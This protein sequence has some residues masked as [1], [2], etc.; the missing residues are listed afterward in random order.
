MKYSTK[1]NYELV[2]S[3]LRYDPET[4]E[5]SKVNGGDVRTRLDPKGY[6]R[7]SVTGVASAAIAHRIAWLLHTG[8]L[9]NTHIDHIDGDK[10]NNKFSNL[11][12]CT[13]IQNQH[14]QPKRRNNKSGYKGVCWMKSSKRWHA[15]ICCNSKIRHL[16]LF[17]DKVE[18]AKA[19]DRAALE[20]HGD[21]SWTNF[22]KEN[23]TGPR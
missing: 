4:G 8:S 7:I 15:Q 21:F 20:L 13:H 14:N 1:Y 5:F 6:L 23:Y 10:L 17:H 19:Y 3:I 22:P 18:A 2:S 11:R 9:P 12:A 16:G